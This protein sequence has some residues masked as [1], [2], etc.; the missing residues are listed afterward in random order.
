MITAYFLTSTILTIWAYSQTRATARNIRVARGSK[1]CPLT[2]T[3][4]TQQLPQNID[5]RL[6]AP[7][8]KEKPTAGAAAGD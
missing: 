8:P 4:A 6:V 5:H 1:S 7:D 2:D 3:E